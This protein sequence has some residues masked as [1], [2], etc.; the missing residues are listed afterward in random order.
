MVITG[1]DDE[2]TACNNWFIADSRARWPYNL[3]NAYKV[4]RKTQTVTRF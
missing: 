3:G 2:T 1:G 4:L